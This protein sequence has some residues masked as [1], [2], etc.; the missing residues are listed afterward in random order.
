MEMKIR[1]VS[2]P[3][4]FFGALAQDKE[5]FG[6]HSVGH[7]N[8]PAEFPARPDV[9]FAIAHTGTE[10]LL[11]YFVREE[12]TLAAVTEDNG[13]VWTDSC[14]EFFI[15]FD[16][17]GYYN[18]ECTCI[19]RALLGFRK[20]REVFT[21]ADQVTLDTILR[22]PSLGTEPFG[23]RRDLA[24]E[25]EIVLPVSAFFSH[26]I[27]DI[28]GMKARGNFYKCGDDLTVPHFLSWQPIDNPNPDFHLEKFF[29]ELE[30]E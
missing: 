4:R 28:S 6:L 25:I 9:R 19:G 23:E 26:R 24:W 21:H 18:L 30:F 1:K 7:V 10:I 20:Q 27:E 13:P 29:G 14:V 3:A 2:D 17:T 11:K 15:S 8:W 16:G 22:R 12:Y 5:A